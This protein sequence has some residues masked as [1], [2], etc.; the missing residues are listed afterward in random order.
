LKPG[1]NPI[2]FAWPAGGQANI[3]ERCMVKTCIHIISVLLLLCGIPFSAAA[4]GSK[5]KKA[6]D[7]ALIFIGSA[8]KHLLFD[9]S[10]NAA[11]RDAARKAA[12]FHSVSADIASHEGGGALAG[13]TFM[14]EFEIKDPGDYSSYLDKLEFN[15]DTDVFESDSAVFVRAAYRGSAGINVNYKP[16]HNNRKP[17]WID[18]GWCCKKYD[19]PQMQP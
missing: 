4:A 10:V 11:L 6:N 8:R 1:S 7:N 2:S 14:Y 17:R 5:Q 16:A 19:E 18:N 15:R 3:K 12:F 13:N 9:D